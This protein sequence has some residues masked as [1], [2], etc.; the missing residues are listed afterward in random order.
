MIDSFCM[1][2]IVRT[3]SIIVMLAVS[4]CNCIN[5]NGDS[6]QG[7]DGAIR[8]VHVSEINSSLTDVHASFL[9]E[10]LDAMGIR[11]CLTRYVLCYGE[12]TRTATFCGT[13]SLTETVSAMLPLYG[14]SSYQKLVVG[15]H[16]IRFD[17]LSVEDRID[18]LLEVGNVVD[19]LKFKDG[20]WSNALLRVESMA[21]SSGFSG[22]DYLTI[23]AAE[24]F[25]D[26]RAKQRGLQQFV[27]QTIRFI[28][29]EMVC[30]SDDDFS[31]LKVIK[32]LVSRY[33][34]DQYHVRQSSECLGVRLRPY[35]D[36]GLMEL[37]QRYASQICDCGT[38]PSPESLA[39]KG[40]NLAVRKRVALVGADVGTYY[41]SCD[42]WSRSLGF[43][44]HP[45]RLSTIEKLLARQMTGDTSAKLLWVGQQRPDTVID[46]DCNRHP[47]EVAFIQPIYHIDLFLHPLGNL[48]GSDTFYYVFGLLNDDWHDPITVNDQRY[49]E[50]QR[51]LLLTEQR[52]KHD[53]TRIGQTPKAIYVPMVFRISGSDRKQ[54]YIA[55]ANGLSENLGNRFR[56]LMPDYM[57]A[58]SSF[59]YDRYVELRQAAIDSIEGTGLVDV[60][61]VKGR[62]ETNSAL[63]CVTQVV[64][65]GNISH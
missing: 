39:V 29:R 30:Q 53:L 17:K 33:A 14:G 13:D 43:K 48:K 55:F 31:C 40:G 27:D 49:R 65:R 62:F 25:W 37:M 56:Y 8:K 34:R 21:D 42:N 1:S 18:F 50:I 41:M 38:Q 9:S 26:E 16:S 6:L 63:H 36:S 3:A 10:T 2:S 59:G 45:K 12:N 44:S 19:S 46:F 61:L 58:E 52:L 24:K 57:A 32:G 60:V 15:G 35:W 64:E 4:S 11:V 22:P 51:N 54:E 23:L 20:V 47:P 28:D 7:N 5:Q